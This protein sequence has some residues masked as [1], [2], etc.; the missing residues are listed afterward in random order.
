MTRTLTRRRLWG[1]GSRG[2]ARE[3]GVSGTLVGFGV[4]GMG[5]KGGLRAGEDGARAATVRGGR[6]EGA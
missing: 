2:D 5:L 6:A 1:W 3:G 4:R